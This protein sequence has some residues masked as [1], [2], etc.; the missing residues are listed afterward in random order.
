MYVIIANSIFRTSE[1]V[2]WTIIGL[3][4]LGVIFI[5]AH[6]L[7]ELFNKKIHDKNENTI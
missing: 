3:G 5:F 7:A 4:L 6:Q 2:L 1:I